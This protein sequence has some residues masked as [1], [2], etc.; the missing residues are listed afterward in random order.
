MEAESVRFV[1]RA[2]VRGAAALVLLF[3]LPAALVGLD[4]AVVAL[5]GRGI[6]PLTGGAMMLAVILLMGLIGGLVA[7]CVPFGR[8]AVVLLV[9]GSLLL[10]VGI[11]FRWF[12]VTADAD[13]QALHDRGVVAAAVVRSHYQVDR[14]GGG[15]DAQVVF[16]SDVQLADGSVLSVES[17]R[18]ARPAV[19]GEVMVTYDPQDRA[20]ARFGS[21][22]GPPDGTAVTVNQ[23]VAI[24]AALALAAALLAPRGTSPG[25][26]R[27]SAR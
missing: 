8:A 10:F 23:A 1:D 12:A 5:H 6:D 17:A 14:S 15:L 9:L 2:P 7:V 16:Y 20:P 25:R 27:R 22:P 18:S 21:R 24:A 19:G 13:R 4:R 26:V 3:A 11:G